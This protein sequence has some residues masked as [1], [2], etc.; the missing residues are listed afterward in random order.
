MSDAQLLRP[1]RA[2]WTSLL[3]LL[4][5][6]LSPVA[7]IGCDQQAQ[8][9]GN[10]KQEQPAEDNE[11]TQDNVQENQPADQQTENQEPEKEQNEE[12]AKE[13]PDAVF[14]RFSEY[15]RGMGILETAVK[16]YQND[17]GVTVD[18]IAVVHIGEKNYYEKL[19]ESF[20]QYDALLYE[21][22]KPEGAQMPANA[23]QGGG[24]SSFQ[25]GFGDAM[26]L[27]F[28]LDHINYRAKNMLHAD[29]T[30]SRFAEVMRERGETPMTMLMKAMQKSM[31]MQNKGKIKQTDGIEMM[32][33]MLSNDPNGL[34]R[35]MARQMS[36]IEE[37]MANMFGDNSIILHER[38][39]RALEVFDEQLKEGK[40]KMGIFY[41]AAH[42]PDFHEKLLKDF[43]FKLVKEQWRPAWI[44]KPN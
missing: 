15:G 2:T 1:N 42:M 25:A 13:D 36:A 21:M 22:V 35:V 14:L 34:K 43:G 12:K 3:L 30:P 24:L 19:D 28:Q 7:F 10:E 27:T 29:M 17:D 26:G 41:G 31:E 20:K 32:A 6:L 38:N 18:L 5:L 44:I 33:A 4:G 11:K 40:K 16:H 39:K 37:D 9:E 23:G 8:G